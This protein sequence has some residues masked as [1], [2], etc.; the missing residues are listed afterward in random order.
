MC[1]EK[2][3]FSWFKQLNYFSWFIDV[4]AVKEVLILIFFYSPNFSWI[5]HYLQEGLISICFPKP[6]L[7]Q[8]CSPKNLF[9]CKQIIFWLDVVL[10]FAGSSDL[11]QELLLC[12]NL[13][14]LWCAVIWFITCMLAFSN[15][16][17]RPCREN[18]FLEFSFFFFCSPLW[19]CC[20]ALC[21][22]GRS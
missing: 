18:T 17:N 10:F 14:L 11:A 19:F 6:T 16:W 1:Y 8:I 2:C 22:L 21:F 4:L 9:F 12:G 3:P 7:R 20:N 5:L 13:R 15:S